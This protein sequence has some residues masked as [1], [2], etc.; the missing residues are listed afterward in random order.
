MFCVQDAP[1][2]LPVVPPLLLEL[3]DDELDEVLAELEAVVAA[4]APLDEVV[5]AVD[6]AEAVGPTLVVLVEDVVDDDVWDVVLVP[7]LPEVELATEVVG[8]V[9]VPAFPEL[10]VEGPA[11]VAPVDPA[12]ARPVAAP[13][14]AVAR[15]VEAPELAVARPVDPAAADVLATEVEAPMVPVE[16]GAH[17]PW[18]M[19]TAPIGQSELT[20]H[21]MWQ[22]P[23]MHLPCAQS[24]SRSHVAK[25]QS[26]PWHPAD[27]ASVAPCAGG[28]P[29]PTAARPSSA[30]SVQLSAPACSSK[31]G[32]IAAQRALPAHRAQVARL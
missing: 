9:V 2:G 16:P 4:T 31:E 3:D 29:Q 18:P 10:L 27:P 5:V 14:L 6:V 30:S 19:Q 23:E 32:C 25:L 28:P 20:A 15:P 21:W 12:E 11:V 24:V 13:E 22:K 7:V 17:R 26:D 1:R 8:E